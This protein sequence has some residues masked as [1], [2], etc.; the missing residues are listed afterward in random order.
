MRMGLVQG[1]CDVFVRCVG[2]LRKVQ[3]LM[4]S[5]HSETVDVAARWVGQ[6]E[7]GV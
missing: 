5:P 3:W 6:I 4:R 7:Y 2:Q 1:K